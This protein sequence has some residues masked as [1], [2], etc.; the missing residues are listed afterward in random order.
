MSKNKGTVL[1]SELLK[2]I[3]SVGLDKTIESLKITQNKIIDKYE[4]LQEIIIKCSCEE[5]NLKS[6]NFKNAKSNYNNTNCMAIISYLLFRHNGYAQTKIANI[7]KKDNSVVSKYIKKINELDD[8]HTQDQ[9]LL[10]K[11]SNIENQVKE[12]KDKILT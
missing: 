7:L 2:T 3:E 9:K 5:F 12:F 11:L 10:F 4:V 8:K 1:L 6:E